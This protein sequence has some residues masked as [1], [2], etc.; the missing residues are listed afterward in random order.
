MATDVIK[1]KVAKSLSIPLSEVQSSDDETVDDFK[2]K[3]EQF[4]KLLNLIKQKVLS[5]K[6]IQKKIHVLTLCPVDWSVNKASKYF[7]VS[8][9][10]IRKSKALVKEKG[11]L[12]NP[13]PKK[14]KHCPWKQLMLLLTFMRILKIQD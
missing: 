4:D 1:E 8:K 5:S 14:G 10:I 9:Y 7:G 2:E 11:I 13:E 12:S 3:A 6:S